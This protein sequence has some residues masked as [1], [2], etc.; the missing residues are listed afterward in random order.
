MVGYQPLPKTGDLPQDPPRP[1][2][3][4]R[5][6]ELIERRPAAP[7]GQT[8]VDT[9]ELV[10]PD[11]LRATFSAAAT[12]M[13]PSDFALVIHPVHERTRVWMDREACVIVRVRGSKAV[14]VG[15]N[16]LDLPAEPPRES[17]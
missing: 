12:W 1:L 2:S 5:V 6:R 14:I 16:L 15:G 17:G 8:P 13:L 10:G 9:L 7:V 11:E 4:V 3:R